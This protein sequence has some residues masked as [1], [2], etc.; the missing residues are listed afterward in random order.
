[1]SAYPSAEP[2]ER[3]ESLPTMYDLP[4]ESAE[5]PGLPDEFHDWQPQLLSQ[6]FCPATYP[7]E[8]VFSA[9]DLNLYYDIR[10][11]SRY[12]RPDWFGVVGVPRLLSNGRLSYVTWREQRRPIVVVELLSPN[13]QEED[14]G[15]TACGQDPPSKWEV[16][17]S[18]L[19]IPY[20]VIYDREGR[21]YRKFV[22]HGG[23]YQEVAD[24]RLW[25]PQLRI[26]IGL[27]QGR[28][29]E[30][31]RTWLRWFDERGRWIPTDV[32]R[33]RQEA[34]QARRE[35]AQERQAREL[36]E[37]RLAELRE[38]LR[39]QGIDPDTLL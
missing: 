18:I 4:S 31:E 36:A 8:Q 30:V 12:K 15:L 26:G 23:E 5:E 17:E 9:S 28:F 24:E 38:R 16:Y 1:M 22:L 27:W 37:Q 11:T 35:A 7:S 29:A 34:E 2:P 33:A 20:Y 39:S 32:E 21:T 25:L 6:T 3:L 14:Q 13:T 10:N 19:Q